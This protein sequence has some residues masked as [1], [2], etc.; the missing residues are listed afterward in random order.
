VDTAFGFC[1]V[2]EH[3]YK[4]KVGDVQ[5]GHLSVLF[6]LGDLPP[7]LLATALSDSGD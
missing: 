6:L 7:M 5:Q 1:L 3:E 4:P 2:K